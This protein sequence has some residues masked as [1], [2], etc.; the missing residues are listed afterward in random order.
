[1]I[2]WSEIINLLVFAGIIWLVVSGA[3]RNDDLEQARTT[4][5][6]IQKDLGLL[7]DSLNAV[8]NDLDV[9]LYDLDVTENE[10][11]ILRT[12]RDLLE[13]EQERR[14]ARNWEELQRLKKEIL[15]AETRRE[16]LLK[17]AEAFEL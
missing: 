4:I 1:M 11:L 3:F 10:L 9:V 14:N 2:K 17:K 13:L 8:Q 5:Q 16:E 7:K 12:D 6:A 15:E